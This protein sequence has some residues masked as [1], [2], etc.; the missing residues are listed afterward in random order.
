LDDFVGNECLEGVRGE[1]VR[2]V[3]HLVGAAIYF[4]RRLELCKESKIS[5]R[6]KTE[7]KWDTRFSRIGIDNGIPVSA[8]CDLLFKALWKLISR[9]RLASSDSDWCDLSALGSQGARKCTIIEPSTLVNHVACSE[10]LNLVSVVLSY[11]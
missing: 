5:D 2:G 8:S 11:L 6:L 10:C 1:G 4:E 3:T 9:V 7:C